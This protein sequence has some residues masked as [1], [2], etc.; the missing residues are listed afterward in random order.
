MCVHEL[1]S[2]AD[3]PT[4]EQQSAQH[5]ADVNALERAF[6]R[7]LSRTTRRPDPAPIR[8]VPVPTTS[9]H[10]PD[11]DPRVEWDPQRYRIGTN[12]NPSFVPIQLPGNAEEL[13]A[14][15]AQ[16]RPEWVR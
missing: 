16:A 13:F 6:A 3:C 8:V 7:A 15:L 12:P 5:E 11:H 9:L 4:P 2:C 10:E 1:T 14:R